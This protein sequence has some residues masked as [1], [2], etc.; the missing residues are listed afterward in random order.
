MPTLGR[1][2][3]LEARP[4]GASSG[5][6]RSAGGVSN[7]L[8]LIHG[9]PLSARMWEP[10]LELANQGWR[11]IAPQLRGFDGAA[12][13]SPAQSMDD[14][15]ADIIDL[16]DAL[17]LDQAVIGGLSMGGYITFALFRHAPRYFRAM[18]L[19]DTRAQ[20]DA[21]Q[22]KEGR[23]RMLEAVRSTGVQAAAAEMLPKLVCDATLRDHPEVVET[24]SRMMLSNST[25][26]VAG[27]I[28]ALM[29]RPDSVPL[30]TGIHCPTL[31]LVGDQDAIT[32]PPLSEDLQRGIKG[33][34]LVV[35]PNAGHM[36]NMEQPQ[37]FNRALSHFLEHRV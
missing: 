22:A 33:A 13:S 18:V 3:Y 28:V 32:P 23:Q 5:I 21:P 1:F 26:T 12:D 4:A 10:Q 6:T 11:V 19:A 31:V 29:T 36:S 37:A 14:Y 27:A 25:E 30:L 24:L 15:A 17:H 8:V 7:T 34:E 16:L 9:F 20:P 35:I 2:R